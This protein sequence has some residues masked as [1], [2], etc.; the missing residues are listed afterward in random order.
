M[1][2]ATTLR[3]LAEYDEISGHGMSNKQLTRALRIS[4]T[5]L[6]RIKALAKHRDAAR[7]FADDMTKRLIVRMEGRRA[8]PAELKI[9]LFEIWQEMTPP[10]PYADVIMVERDPS[11]P[12]RIVVTL[13]SEI[14]ERLR[15]KSK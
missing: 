1:S 8:T 5:N 6:S 14:S 3:I 15:G 2:D 4:Q 13:P 12:N 7:R 10:D 9:A 11:E